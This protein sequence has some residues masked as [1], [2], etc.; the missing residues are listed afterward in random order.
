[1]GSSSS[2]LKKDPSI[3][4]GGG[5][6]STQSTNQPSNECP[7]VFRVK[8]DKPNNILVG[9]KIGTL[10]STK[11]IG[12][13]VL[14]YYKLLKVVILSEKLSKRIIKCKSKGYHYQAILHSIKPYVI[15]FSRQ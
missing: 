9:L 4:Q 8:I 13:K 11:I 6:G 7:L 2:S 1:M 15:V 14:I 5:F 12:D 3:N 10:M